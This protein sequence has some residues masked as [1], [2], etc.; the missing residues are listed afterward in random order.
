VI[1]AGYHTTWAFQSLADCYGNL[2]KAPV[3]VLRA[4]SSEVEIFPRDAQPRIRMAQF[5]EKRGRRREA[6]TQYLETVRIRPEDPYFSKQALERAIKLEAYDTA[7]EVLAGMMKRW[8][9][10]GKV[11]NKP[12]KEL[13]ALLERFHGKPDGSVSPALA[14]KIQRYVERDLVVILSWDT[15]GTDVDLHVTDPAGEECSYER[16]RTQSGGTLDHD[17][18]DGLGPETF[19]LK[20]AAPGRFKI[21]VVYYSGGAPTRC[22]LRIYRHRNGKRETLVTRTANLRK[23]GERVLV[24]ALEVLKD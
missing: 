14:G 2:K 1:Q 23:K 4:V 10:P 22:T 20:H 19:S 3:E 17:D 6:L 13:M 8:P 7:H 9:N 11:W 24:D 21:E 5:F 18:T 12:E 16:K 15:Q